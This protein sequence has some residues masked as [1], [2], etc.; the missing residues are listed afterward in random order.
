GHRPVGGQQAGGRGRDPVDDLAG[1][2]TSGRDGR[3]RQQ[4][5]GSGGSLQDGQLAVGPPDVDAEVAGGHEPFRR[6]SSSMM[7]AV[8]VAPQRS[9]P[10]LRPSMSRSRVRMPP[11]AFTLTRSETL[12]RI[13]RRSSMVAPDG[14]YPVEVF[15]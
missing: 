5:R 7:A 4:P 15:T 2:A 10:A 14:A 12:A 13:S 11:A 6:R 9:M 1:V 3:G 8:A